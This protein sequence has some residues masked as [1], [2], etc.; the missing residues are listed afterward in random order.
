LFVSTAAF[1]GTLY[2]VALFFQNGLGMTAL[3]S[4]LS[5]FPE[6]LG[7]MV[8]AQVATRVLYPRFG[9]RRLMVGGLLLVALTVGLMA[10]IDD[11]SQLWSMR[12]LMF[13]LGY[14]MA[15]NFVSSQAAG[16]ARVSPA[17]TGRAST[18]FNAL[19]QLGAASGIAVLT[20]ALTLTGVSVASQGAGSDLHPYHVA[21]VVAAALAVLAS[22]LATTVKDADADSTRKAKQAPEPALA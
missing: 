6:A 19:R 16:L 15:H 9:P 10:L 20:S 8:G 11:R 17:D 1:L 7:V 22:G 3:Q 13:F 18:M 14:A 2:L 21:F 12:V 5:T 4:G